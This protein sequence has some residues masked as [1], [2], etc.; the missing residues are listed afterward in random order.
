MESRSFLVNCRIPYVLKC[1]IINCYLWLYLLVILNMRCTT[2]QNIFLLSKISFNQKDLFANWFVFF[3]LI[4][5]I[6]CSHYTFCKNYKPFK[7]YLLINSQNGAFSDTFL[8]VKEWYF[9]RPMDKNYLL[10]DSVSI[11]KNIEVKNDLSMSFISPYFFYF[12]ELW[13]HLSNK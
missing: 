7:K 9:H 4:K 11:M 1:E 10:M 8:S 6:L 12:F 13:C 3:W 2:E 5:S